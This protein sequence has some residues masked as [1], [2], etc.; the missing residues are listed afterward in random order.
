MIRMSQFNLLF[1]G[2]GSEV[3]ISPARKEDKLF[4]LHDET[5]LEIKDSLRLRVS[6]STLTAEQKLEKIKELLNG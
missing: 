3:L 6:P 2:R 4:V 5:T 1:D